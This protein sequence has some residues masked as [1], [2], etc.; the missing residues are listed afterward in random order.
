MKNLQVIFWKYIQIK[1]W[2]QTYENTRKELT[3]FKL[4]RTSHQKCSVKKVFLEISQNSQENNCVR[5]SFLK[6]LVQV[7][8]S[9]FC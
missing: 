3:F 1:F 8:S 2:L 5:D 9:E 6:Y 4:S 7:L